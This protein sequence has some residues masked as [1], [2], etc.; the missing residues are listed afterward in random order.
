VLKIIT[1]SLIFLWCTACVKNSDGMQV[2]IQNTQRWSSGLR[3]NNQPGLSGISEDEIYIWGTRGDQF[4]M[5]FYSFSG[6]KLR[7]IVFNKGKGPGEIQFPR[8]AKLADEKIFIYDYWL[9]RINIYS[10]DGKI[11]D[12]IVINDSD[13][14]SISDLFYYKEKIYIHCSEK[15][16]LAAIDMTGTVVKKRMYEPSTVSSNAD[17]TPI[18]NG[19]LYLNDRERSLYIAYS[20]TPLRIDVFDLALEKTDSMVIPQ[21]KKYEPYRFQLQQ[22]GDMT[23]MSSVGD[24]LASSVAFWKDYILL[25]LPARTVQTET[26]DLPKDVDNGFQLI[27]TRKK[28][29]AGVAYDEVFRHTLGLS[30]YILGVRKNMIICGVYATHKES[31]ER[32]YGT[33]SGDDLE[34][35]VFTIT[36]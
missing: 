15:C 16:L 1:V 7:E 5:T 20:N 17:E 3:A 32:S 23:F 26:K 8:I 11:I 27:N 34:I 35:F 13:L 6:E 24:D 18:L 33:K 31:Y 22:Y 14:S 9:R 4:L 21:H 19:A 29:V 12:D 36:E 25:P 30:Y 2:T 10:L 28:Q